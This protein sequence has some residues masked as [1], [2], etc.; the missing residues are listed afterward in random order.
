M[1][2][3]IRLGTRGSPLALKQAERVKSLL[4]LA[5]PNLKVAILVIKTTGDIDLQ[6]P[7]SQIGGKGVFIK[8]LEEAL[9]NQEI[10][11]AVHSLKD[12]T[13]TPHLK[14][15]LSGFLKA[16]SVSDA[17]VSKKGYTLLSLPQNA[18]VATGSLRRKALLKKLRPDINTVDIR[19]NIQTRMA[20][21]ESP[22]IDAILLSQAGLIRMGITLYS[23][24]TLNPDIFYPAPGQGVIALQTRQESTYKE[25]CK[26]INSAEEEN[27]C[28][29]SLELLA[30]LGFDCRMPLAIHTKTTDQNFNMTLFLANSSLTRWIEE[31]CRFTAS[32]WPFHAEVLIEKLTNFIQR[33]G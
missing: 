20:K 25:L 8:E 11:I 19:G 30:H 4:N 16:E 15:C 32:E 2:S 29:Y 6:S 27:R 17:L 28:R 13:A 5:H 22:G 33:E 31:S 10:D 21:L 9:L 1:R 14:L 12:V 18:V 23:I 3:E 26:T 24:V 7:L